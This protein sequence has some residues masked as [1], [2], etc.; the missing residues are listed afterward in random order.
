MKSETSG[1]GCV[2]AGLLEQVGRAV[3]NDAF[4]GGLKPAQ[5]AALRYFGQAN[6]FSR[7]VS[8]FAEFQGTTRGTAS[9][10]LNALVNKGYLTRELAPRDRRS[11]QIEIA[12][13]GWALLKN[14]PFGELA[15]AVS[16]LTPDQRSSLAEGLD[17]ILSRMLARRGQPR[18]G[19]CACCDHLRLDADGEHPQG[20]HA[21]DL[22]QEPLSE[23]ETRQICVNHS[24]TA[25]G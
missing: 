10:T 4:T 15:N 11:F 20:P 8:A 17:I 18:F 22:L 19:M 23:Q 12:P 14:D 21:C 7:T 25:P 13:Q 1:S 6:R 5:W 9:Q 3:H 16:A 2:V 24:S